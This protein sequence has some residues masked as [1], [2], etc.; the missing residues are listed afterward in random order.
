MNPDLTKFLN[1]KIEA[2]NLLNK[3]EYQPY[4]EHI[5]DDDDKEKLLT[6][7]Q[8]CKNRTIRRIRRGELD[9]D[10]NAL[11]VMTLEEQREFRLISKD[12]EALC[13]R[14]CHRCILMYELV[15]D[16]YRDKLCQRCFEEFELLKIRHDFNL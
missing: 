7:Q 11:A 10:A 14:Y 5:N 12:P 2:Q 8:S 4:D 3:I 1:L 15:R 6:E 13:K 16:R 9:L